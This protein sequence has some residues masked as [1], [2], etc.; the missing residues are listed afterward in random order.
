M[1][2]IQFFAARAEDGALLPRAIIDVYLAGTQ[3]RTSLYSDDGITSIDNPFTANDNAE[4]FCYSTGERVD[5]QV[6]RGAYTAPLIK[7]VLA[8]DP[9]TLVEE[10]VAEELDDVVDAL[11]QPKV[12]EAEAARD[13]AQIARDG[14][15]IAKDQAIAAANATGDVKIYDDKVAANDALAGLSEDQIVEVLVDE[16][17]NDRRTRYRVESASLVFKVY[18]DDKQIVA[19]LAELQA[20]GT[21][22]SIGVK[23]EYQGLTYVLKNDIDYTDAIAAD[24]V[25]IVIA[26]TYSP[27]AAWVAVLPTKTITPQIFGVIGDCNGAT[28]NGNDDTVALR[29]FF[30]AICAHNLKGFGTDLNCR[31]TGGLEYED[32]F[33]LKAT[34]TFVIYRDYAD[35]DIG[36]GNSKYRTRMP[37]LSKKNNG[38]FLGYPDAATSYINFYLDGGIWEVCSGITASGSQIVCART[39]NGYINTK[40]NGYEGDWAVVIAGNNW[41]GDVEISGG[42]ALYE[43]GLHILWG[44]NVRIGASRVSSGGDDAV[45]IGNNFGMSCTDIT[46]NGGDLSSMQGRAIRIFQ[47]AIKSGSHTGADGAST[48]TDSAANLDVDRY[49]GETVYNLRSGAS[50]VI[51]ANTDKTI[52][53]ALSGGGDQVWNASD[54]YEI[55]N[56]TAVVDRVTVTATAG[57]GGLGA[58]LIEGCRSLPTSVR[59]IEADFGVGG[60]NGVRDAYLS[61]LSATSQVNG[62]AVSQLYTGTNIVVRGRVNKAYFQSFWTKNTVETDSHVIANV[63]TGRYALWPH[64]TSKK[65]RWYGDV[66]K[67]SGAT[68][69]IGFRVDA[70]VPEQLF[71]AE[72]IRLDI[73]TPAQ[74]TAGNAVINTVHED[75]IGYTLNSATLDPGATFG[76]VNL[77]SSI[78]Y[79]IARDFKRFAVA[80]NDWWNLTAVTTGA[81]EYRRCLLCVNSTGGRL[82]IIG[83]PGSITDAEYPQTPYGYAA[84][85]L[86]LIRP[87]YAG[88]AIPAADIASVSAWFR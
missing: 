77:A 44:D 47:S 1:Q 49:V 45:A 37:S 67:E 10:L 20:I 64:N 79:K 28:G 69:T 51:T 86:V 81:S 60:T 12:D 48:L 53:A 13:L 9:L 59:N 52:S 6:R 75:I 15:V 82:V 7:N 66:R 84:V 62:H 88:G 31:I 18:M 30:H 61:G 63:G 83:A 36:N 25:G 56:P 34:S 70:T 33:Y 72:G 76:Y 41:K 73:D 78:H 21:N 65:M 42:D 26:T 35:P 54:D 38:N 17:L 68:G 80:T 29:K 14:A 19:T 16:S 71:I 55:N 87:S 46:V 4:V 5:I 2:P 32:N 23:R 39:N 40:V 24:N 57:N 8:K 50:G 43:D 58:V 74:S 27:A 22:L 11:L 85:G 3:T